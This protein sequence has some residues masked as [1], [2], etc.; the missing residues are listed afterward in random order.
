[1]G[2][3]QAV[4][5]STIKPLVM[6]KGCPSCHSGSVQPP[7]FTSYAT[8]D[9]KYRTGPVTTNILL[10]EAGDGAVHNGVTYFTADEKTTIKGW[11]MGN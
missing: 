2:G 3:T 1:M 9:A 8:L 10:T 11:I 7:N 4:F 5:D 6:R